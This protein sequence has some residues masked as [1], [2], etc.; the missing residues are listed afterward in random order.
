M[1]IQ[2]N[3]QGSTEENHEFNSEGD[4]TMDAVMQIPKSKLEE[5]AGWFLYFAAEEAR[6]S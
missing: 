4:A 1:T 5:I 6:Y 3:Q 2:N